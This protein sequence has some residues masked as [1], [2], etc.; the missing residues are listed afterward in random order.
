M[1]LEAACRAL[2]ETSL[3]LKTIATQ[4]GHADEQALRRAFQRELGIGPSD[5]RARFSG[6]EVE[7]Q[8][9]QR[10]AIPRAL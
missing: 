4:V 10:V 6:H 5:Y 2:E 8:P 7:A 9:V 3:P 1:R